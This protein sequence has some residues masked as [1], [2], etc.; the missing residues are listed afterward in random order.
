MFNSNYSHSVD[1]KGRFIMPAKYRDLLDGRCMVTKGMDN[2]CLYIYTLS[3]W[4]DFEARLLALPNSKPEIRALQRYFLSEAEMVE[5]DKQGRCLISQQLREYAGINSSIKLLGMGNKV[6]LWSS[7]NLAEFESKT[8][9][10]VA[11][12][13]GNIDFVI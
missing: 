12:V 6:E 5:I 1:D 4:A 13:A 10:D 11:D 9:V 2:R 3:E 8:T 7:E